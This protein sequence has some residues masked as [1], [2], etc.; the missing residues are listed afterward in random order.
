M[1]TSAEVY[2]RQDFEV[3]DHFVM[4]TIGECGIHDRAELTA[5]LNLPSGLV[6]R[7]LAFLATIQQVTLSGTTVDL[8]PL[9]ARSL[10]DG[11][12]YV[13]TTSR[14][15]I[16]I[17]RQLGRPFPRQHYDGNVTVLD[18]T[19]IEDGQLADRSRFLSV[20]TT[21]QYRPEV[22]QWLE[23]HPDR[24]KFN[25][26]SQLRNL[27][28]EGHRDGYLPC[29]LIETADHEILAYTNVAEERDAFLEQVCIETAIE[30][31]IEAKRIRRPQEVWKEWLAESKTYG[32]GQLKETTD[33]WQ[34]VLDPGAFGKPPKIPPT[35]IGS[36]QFRDNHFIQVWSADPAARRQ[37]LI[38]RSLGIAT[39][40]D[41][42]SMPHLE[43]R[44]RDLAAKLRIPA[45][46]VDDLRAH[47]R[48]TG[49]DRRLNHLA[50][51]AEKGT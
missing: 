44:I 8:A 16:L 27:R 29:Y 46:S 49:D 7:C 24:A 35:R 45:A 22:L 6:D 30:H 39:L 25:L 31:L 9:G 28:E 43:T 18:T 33:G 41:I 42:T 19:E 34:V 23:Q 11:V 38:E 2:D 3:I 36:Y 37:A 47:A 40:P 4:R 50:T 12:R 48:R 14:L 17:E 21:A 32:A 5:F 1:E 26:P 13:P 51:L 15:T 20:F 10:S